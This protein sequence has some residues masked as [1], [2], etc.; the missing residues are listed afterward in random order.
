MR[1]NFT[2]VNAASVRL[3]GRQVKERVTV[4]KQRKKIALDIGQALFLTPPSHVPDDANCYWFTLGL[5]P[6]NSTVLGK[7]G[8]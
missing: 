4:R 5:Q 7:S 8:L 2:H 6:S 3:R 1:D